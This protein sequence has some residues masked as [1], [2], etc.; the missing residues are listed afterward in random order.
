MLDDEKPMGLTVGYNITK[1]VAEELDLKNAKEE[2]SQNCPRK[3]YFTTITS[4][5]GTIKQYNGLTSL[6][7]KHY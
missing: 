7:D 1:Y 6:I 5:S 2:R 3:Y 4:Y